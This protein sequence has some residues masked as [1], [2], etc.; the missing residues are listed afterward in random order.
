MTG[1]DAFSRRYGLNRAPPITVREDAPDALREQLPSMLVALGIDIRV[2][3]RVVCY[4]L[5]KL[6]IEHDVWP[7]SVATEVDEL[8]HECAWWKVYDVAEEMYNLLSIGKESSAR[9]FEKALNTLLVDTGIGWEMLNGKIVARGSEA[10]GAAAQAAVT[11]LTEVAK[12][13]AAAELR[14]ALS[15]LSRRPDAD[16]TGAIQHSIAALECVARE[17]TGDPKATLGV[18]VPKLGLPKPLDAAVEKTWGY[19]SEVGRHLRE[20]RVPGFD[21]AELVVTVSAAVATYLVKR[22]FNQ[23]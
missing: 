14:E 8:M 10:F 18:L 16:V 3:R 2:V 17:V 21:E 7:D 23:P 12:P 1:D 5:T 13:T 6:P 20:G 15:D 4:A 19:A 22:G 9:F 11:A